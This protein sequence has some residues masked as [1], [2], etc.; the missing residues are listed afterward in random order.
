MKI[1][2]AL[3]V[4]LAFTNAC[5]GE[6]STAPTPMTP[7]VVVV[8][9]APTT[10]MVSGRITATNGGQ[11][12]A[13]IAVNLGSLT[14]QSDLGGNFSSAL[15]FGAA[16]IT[17]NAAM[18]V[19]RTLTAAITMNRTLNLDAITLG[20][21]FDHNFYRQLVRNAYADP[22][23]SEPLRRWTVNP[24]IYLR[25]VNEAGAVMD[26]KTLDVTE[27]VLRETTPMWTAGQLS[28]AAIERGTGTKVGVAGWITVRFAPPTPNTTR[29]GQ[30]QVGISGGWIDLYSNTPGIECRCAGLSDIRPRTVRH[31]LGHALGFWH[32]DSTSDLMS[33]VAVAGCDA[34]PSARERYHAA[35]AY[36]RPV[37]NTEPDTDP[38]STLAL[39]PMR[40]Q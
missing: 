4:A 27:A 17:L 28:V 24:Q 19:P 14:M 25:T 34:L 35:I 13:G 38:T 26:L 20:G 9:P 18:I 10:A 29:C 21:G 15:P 31:E 6:R 8:P 1:L 12:L 16:R 32:T 5:G 37:G 36:R 7:P 39:V 2:C 30:A 11:P 23:F 33:G 22:L 40:V 3:G